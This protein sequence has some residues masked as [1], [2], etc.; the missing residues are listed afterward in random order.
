MNIEELKELQPHLFQSFQTILEQERL[1]HAYL[2]SGLFASFEMALF[3]SQAIFCEDK[4]MNLP[5]GKCRI[6]RL[7]EQGEFADVTVIRPQGNMIK[8][9][10]IREVVKQFSQ[11]GFESTQQVFIICEAEKM[12]PNAANALLKVIEEPQSAIRIFLLTNQEHAVLA[13]IKSRVQIVSFPKNIPVLEHLLEEEGLLK[14]QAQLTAQLVSG[15]AEARE[16]AKNKSFLDLLAKLSKWL[17]LLLTQ[18]DK[19]YL[20]V[21]SLIRLTT[22]K[23]EQARLFDMLALLLANQLE[24]P[25]V[26]CYL[27]T[28]PQARKQWQSHV[29]VQNALEYW[30]LST[31]QHMKG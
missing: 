31:E 15:I 28:L 4:K 20:Q 18:P 12:H 1:A 25:K 8:T 30:L 2:F 17:P 13:T 16:L 22:E 19:A 21:P 11:S 27:E 24:S 10:T 29:S 5:C 9:D 14:T 23:V 7:I 26:R 3:L 6:C